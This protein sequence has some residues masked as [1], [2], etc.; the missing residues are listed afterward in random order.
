MKK[1][2]FLILSICSHFAFAQIPTEVLVGNRQ[3][4][5]I[6]YWQKDIDAAGKLNLF[7]FSRFAI[8]HRNS[9][10]N[11][12]SLEAQLT[13]Q[14]KDWIGISAGGGYAGEDFM[15]AI[16]LSLSHAS[17]KGDFFI[18]AYPTLLLDDVK[19]F[20]VLGIV[21]YMPTLNDKWGLFTQ[22]IFSTNLQLDKTDFSPT[23]EILGVF[24]AH[25]QSSQLIRVGLNYKERFQFGIGAD[26]NQFF[27]NTGNFQNVGLFVRMNL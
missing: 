15:P 1:V 3:T 12:F 4:H 17:K 24:T 22:L 25:Q 11:N 2:L 27:Q 18:E 21:G 10:Y 8:D 20:N 13:Y 26:F 5:Y 23:R 9:M 14:I 19:A 6:S 7:T 16:G